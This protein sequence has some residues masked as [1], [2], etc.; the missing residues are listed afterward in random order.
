MPTGT[1][2]RRCQTVA[3]QRAAVSACVFPMRHPLYGKRFPAG[4]TTPQEPL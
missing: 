3:Q 2:R 4:L 1:A